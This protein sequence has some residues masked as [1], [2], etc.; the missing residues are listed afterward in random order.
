MLLIPPLVGAGL[1]DVGIA[2]TIGLEPPGCS[3]SIAKLADYRFEWVLAGHGDRIKLP[4]N[5]MKAK[6]RDL[7]HRR[8]HGHASR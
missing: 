6:L 1:P 2:A 4:A 7:V 8:H 5:V 3:A